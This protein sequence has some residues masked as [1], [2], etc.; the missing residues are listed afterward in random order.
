MRCFVADDQLF[1]CL[2]LVEERAAK[3]VDL[4]YGHQGGA[5]AKNDW[6]VG[7]EPISKFQGKAGF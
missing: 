4:L 1:N 6:R 7:A 2:R 5:E 3:G